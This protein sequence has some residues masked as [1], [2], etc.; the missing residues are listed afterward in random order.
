MDYQR[1]YV[2]FIRD[3]RIRELSLE[4][5]TEG[6]H[7]LPRC[8]GGGDEPDNLIR[9][10]AEDHVF[11]HLLLA[12][13]WG[14][15]LWYPLIQMLRLPRQVKGASRGPRAIRAAATARREQRKLQTGVKR[16]DVSARLKG[17]P[18]SPE[19]RKSLS[20]SRTGRRDTPETRA[21][22]SAA[23]KLRICTPERNAK[24]SAALRGRKFSQEHR[25]KISA[26]AKQRHIG[27]GNPRYDRTIRSFVHDDGRV[28]LMTKY[29]LAKKYGLN[30]SCL[31]Y[32]IAGERDKTGG[33]RLN[34][35][36]EETLSR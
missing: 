31:N 2:V 34:G 36:S 12:K 33:W 27:S 32:V 7:I 20:I 26:G 21:K 3:R 4:G 11:A 29:D 9:L 22:K 23:M 5:Y 10:S 25:A 6:H 16:P 19:H 35:A 13:G 28:E 14:G 17:R 24:L 15:R 18:K 30:R 8:M 1:I